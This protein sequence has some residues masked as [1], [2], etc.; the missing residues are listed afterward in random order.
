MVSVNITNLP[1][2]PQITM[3]R[4]MQGIPILGSLKNTQITWVPR[5]FATR[6]RRVYPP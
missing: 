1:L 4:R 2:S 6:L 5:G 3:E